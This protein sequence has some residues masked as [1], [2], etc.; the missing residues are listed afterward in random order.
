M[1]RRGRTISSAPA[2]RNHLP[3][4][5]PSNELLDGGRTRSAICWKLSATVP[6]FDNCVFKEADQIARLAFR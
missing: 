3:F 1:K 5:V 4:T 6:C 2:T